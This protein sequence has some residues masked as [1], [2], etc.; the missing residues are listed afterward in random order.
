[1]VGG[2]YANVTAC[3]ISGADTGMSG[4]NCHFQAVTSQEWS[5]EYG[6]LCSYMGTEE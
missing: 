3:T 4:P 6:K 5:K 1:M 2:G